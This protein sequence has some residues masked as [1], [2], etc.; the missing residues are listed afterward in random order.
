[1][2][3]MIASVFGLPVKQ[4]NGEFR[5]VAKGPE[6]GPFTAAPEQ[7]ARLVKQGLAR[8]V[9]APA[10]VVVDAPIG[11]D[12]TPDEDALPDGVTGIPKYS[13]D[14]K[15][16]ELREIGALCGL[17]FKVGMTKAEMVAELD[18]H[19]AENSVDGYEVEDETPDEDAPTFDPAEA[20]Q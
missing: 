11:F 19:I 10:P 2:I 5:V 3:E 1:M 4:K 18:K 8:R 14:M 16:T 15:A 6:D 20:V 12:E 17:S 7:E 13:V 9:D